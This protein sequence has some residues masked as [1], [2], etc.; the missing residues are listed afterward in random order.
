MLLFNVPKGGGSVRGA[1]FAGLT[2]LMVSPV[3]LAVIVVFVERRRFVLGDQYLAFLVG[4]V[5][6]A[7]AVTIGF[8]VRAGRPVWSWWLLLPI[9]AGLVFGLW[10]LQHEVAVGIYTTGEAHSPSKLWHQFICYPALAALVS[11]SVWFAWGRWTPLMLMGLLVTG[12]VALN[13][14][15]RTHPKDPHADFTWSAPPPSGERR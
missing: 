9:A 15:D 1:L 14:W 6:L 10:Q 3:G 13:V 11:R 7:V 8:A 5:L 2:S 12:W 4:D